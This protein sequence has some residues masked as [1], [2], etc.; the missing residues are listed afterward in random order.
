MKFC[1][2]LPAACLLLPGLL[3][4]QA[5]AAADAVYL[6]AR[7]WTGDSLNPAAEALAVRGGRLV[8]VGREA[9]IRMLVGPAT[10]VTDLGGQRVVPGFIDAHWHLP[11]Q[12]RADLVGAGNVQEIVKRLQ[13][14]AARLPKGAWVVG[15][16]WTPSDFP[17][18]AAHKQYLD[19]AFPSQPVFITDRDGHQAL[20]NSVALRLAQVTAAT[21]DPAQ[22]VVE[23]GAGGVPTG[24]LKESASG[25]VSRL[26]PPPSAADISRRIHEETRAAA[27]HGI[28]MV[29]EA[30][31]REASGEVFEVLAAAAKADTMLLRWYVSVPFNPGAT[32]AQL[33]SYV[34][35][36]Q[37]FSGPWLRYGIAKG[38]LDGT[39]DAQTAA[40]LE[41]YA[42]TDATGLPFWSASQLNGGVVRYDSAGLQVELHAIGDKAVRMALDAFA[43]A[44]RANGKRDS[45]HRVEHIEVPHPGD[46]PR[47]KQLGVIASTQAIFATPDVTTLTNYAPLLGPKRAALSN[48][49]KQFDDAGARQAFGSDYPVFPMDVIR[50]MYTAVTRMT[51]EGTPRGGWYPAGRI[52]V[53]A[54][55][56]HYTRDAAYAAFMENDAGMLRAG[57][58]ADFV[59]LSDDLL[60]MPPEQMLRVKVV[61]T[62]VGGRDAYVAGGG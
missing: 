22:G 14:W 34:A 47:F 45:R 12:S 18:N 9:D 15:R 24:L 32:R 57:M 4:A 41:P 33:A 16:G 43:Q 37:R 13:A 48:N 3:A 29:H 40:M 51:P 30:S 61:R 60:R 7:V 6:N 53:E 5:T 55:L 20:A 54:A 59:V 1:S 39:V 21:K 10:K 27:S 49:F 44:Q 11:T 52:T 46:L 35:L 19:A 62:V 26:I 28:T 36:K 2:L 50:G 8:G 58:L 42:N 38:M 23:R 17:Q 31:R 25:L 56:R